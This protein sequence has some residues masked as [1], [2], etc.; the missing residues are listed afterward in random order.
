MNRIRD[1]LFEEPSPDNTLLES[2]LQLCEFYDLPVSMV[3]HGDYGSGKTRFLKCLEATAKELD[4]PCTFFHTSQ[5]NPDQLNLVNALIAKMGA[6]YLKMMEGKVKRAK[7]IGI[8]AGSLD[9]FL[10][11]IGKDVSILDT[12][13]KI[14]KA[15][16]IEKKQLLGNWTSYGDPIE[17]LKSDFAKMVS[18]IST[19][20]KDKPDRAK[21]WN[22]EFP[23]PWIILFD[24]L[25]R[26]MPNVALDLILSLRVLLSSFDYDSK[27]RVPVLFLF[28]LNLDCL[29]DAIR[30][31]YE[32][33]T[34]IPEKQNE[35]IE[36]FLRKYFI[37][38][39][40]IPSPSKESIISS[41]GSRMKN[42]LT[43]SFLEFV[44]SVDNISCRTLFCVLDRVEHYY[45]S[46]FQNRITENHLIASY[47]LELLRNNLE[48]DFI[49][50]IC[51]YEERKCNSNS[52]SF[53]IFNDIK[54]E[55]TKYYINLILNDEKYSICRDDIGAWNGCMSHAKNVFSVRPL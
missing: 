19:L 31:R 48:E 55:A 47:V 28:A 5:Y 39:P 44:L 49:K 24:D 14:S 38:G 23:L 20:Y 54:D 53:V 4:I 26:L 51:K 45:I 16:E 43:A 35:F 21:E 3:M 6:Q 13:E 40:K 17:I 37:F 11:F 25:D 41:C 30:A 7:I 27:K 22:Y 34:R 1:A 12:M 52:F 10:S 36:Q 9:V 50:T 2:V 18:D 32:N 8:I 42:F 46:H 33:I 15:E 29:R